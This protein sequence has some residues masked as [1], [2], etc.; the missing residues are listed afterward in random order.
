MSA[1]LRQARHQDLLKDLRRGIAGRGSR[2][3]AARDL[4]AVAPAGI[5]VG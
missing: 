5:S 1:R 4:Y 2:S 3:H